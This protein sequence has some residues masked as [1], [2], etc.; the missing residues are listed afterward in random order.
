MFRNRESAGEKLAERLGTYRDDPA[1]LILALPRGGVAVGYPLSLALRLP[2]DVLITR[3]LRAPDNPEYALGAVS[4]TGYVYLN[5]EAVSFFSE[6]EKD[7]K[8]YLDQEI[9]FQRQEI[10]RRQVLFRDGRPLPPLT[11]RTVILV[12]D[13]IA[14]GA[15]FLASVAALKDLKVKRLVAAIPVGPP[16]RIHQVGRKVDEVVALW[17]PEGFIAVGGYYEDFTQVEDTD[18]VRYLKAAEALRERARLT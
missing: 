15:T 3:K 7:F 11:D 10:A 8:A 13:G 14:T 4:E 5:P 18:V 1:G 6:Y 16:E 9:S 12:D 17:E 2:L